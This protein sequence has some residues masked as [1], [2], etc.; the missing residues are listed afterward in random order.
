MTIPNPVLRRE[1]INLYKQLLHL[2]K[3]YPLG[4]SY[5]RPRLHKAFMS[6]ASITDEERIKEGIKRGEFVVKGVFPLYVHV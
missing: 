6:N 2:G 4:F 5:F 1:V 3:N